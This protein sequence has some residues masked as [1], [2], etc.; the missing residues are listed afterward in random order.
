MNAIPTAY[1]IVNHSVCY[2]NPVNGVHTNTIEG[3][4]AGIKL[5]I[6]ARGKVTH[7]VNLYLVRYMI[8]KNESG[9]PLLNLI[10]YLFYCLFC[11]YFLFAKRGSKNENSC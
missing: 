3:S 2:K 7:K 11:V 4:W 1:Q 10:K 6:P 5:N 8:I 9:S